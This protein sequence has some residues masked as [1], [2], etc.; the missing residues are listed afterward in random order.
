MYFST[1]GSVSFSLGMLVKRVGVILLLIVE[2]LFAHLEQRLGL[3]VAFRG[4]F[5]E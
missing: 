2:A 5:F 3:A 1:H 4:P